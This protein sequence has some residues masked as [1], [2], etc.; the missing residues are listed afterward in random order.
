MLRAAVRRKPAHGAQR[1]QIPKLGCA[2]PC[3][4]QEQAVRGCAVSCK[5]RGH[6]EPCRGDGAGMRRSNGGYRGTMGG[7]EDVHGM[8]RG[9][10]D[11]V[12]R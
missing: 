2:V 9:G 3:R 11:E 6:E 12:G 4:S 7:V 5:G 8:I 1:A 10:G